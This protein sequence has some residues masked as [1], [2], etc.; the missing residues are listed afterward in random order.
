MMIGEIRDNETAQVAV[1]AA[2]TGHLVLS[3]LHTNS[4]AGAVQRLLN[5]EI[6][7]SDVASAANAFISQ[8]L[9]RKLCDCKQP[10][11]MTPEQKEK[12]ASVLKSVSKKALPVMPENYVIQKAVG[13]EK[14]NHLGYKGRLT[15]M[16]VFTIDRDIQSLI[17]NN[18]ISIQLEEKA[19]ENGMLTLVQDGILKVL[20]GETTLEEIER[21]TNL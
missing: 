4:A 14:C 8:R 11:E 1:Q 21:V 12:I 16:E 15:L 13:C 17:N 7:P 2:L 5:M 10:A 9:V 6:A 3:T 19:I 18:A 20:D